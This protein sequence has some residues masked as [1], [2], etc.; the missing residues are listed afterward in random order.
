M[1][2]SNWLPSEDDWIPHIAESELLTL[3][4]ANE[5]ITDFEWIE[6]AKQ[7]LKHI[8]PLLSIS[9]TKTAHQVNEFHKM[10]IEYQ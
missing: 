10:M 1:A 7:V 3:G 8:N 4:A 5:N 2:L 6:Y 9:D